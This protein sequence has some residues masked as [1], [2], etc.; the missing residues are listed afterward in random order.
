M[1]ISNIHMQTFGIINDN[2]YICEE[3]QHMHD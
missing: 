3:E 2:Y 1:N